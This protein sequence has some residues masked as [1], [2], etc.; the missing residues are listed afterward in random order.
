M[1]SQVSSPSRHTFALRFDQW[2]CRPRWPPSATML[3]C[4]R[5][6]AGAE[7]PFAVRGKR[8]LADVFRL[9]VQSNLGEAPANSRG[10]LQKMANA[11]NGRWHGIALYVWPL[12]HATM[13]RPWRHISFCATTRC[14][15]SSAPHPQLPSPPTELPRW[16]VILPTFPSC[17]TNTTHYLLPTFCPSR[18]PCKRGPAS[19]PTTPF[20]GSRRRPAWPLRLPCPA[21]PDFAHHALGKPCAHSAS[22]RY[23]LD[24]PA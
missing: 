7:A 21:P 12:L 17:L 24:P 18:C 20:A 22:L 4:R 6:C 10:A 13:S 3:P 23:E 9:P 2:G 1:A 11:S 8:S 16:Q 19:T 15:L 5:R 14:D